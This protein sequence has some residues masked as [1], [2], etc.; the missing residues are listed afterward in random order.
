MIITGRVRQQIELIDEDDEE[1]G[2][3]KN[4]MAEAGQ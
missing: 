3:Q 1:L 2:A 4:S